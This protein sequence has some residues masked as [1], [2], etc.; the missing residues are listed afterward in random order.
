MDLSFEQPFESPMEARRNPRV[1]FIGSNI[2]TAEEFSIDSASPST[3][4]APPSTDMVATVR[5]SSDLDLTAITSFDVDTDHPDYCDDGAIIGTVFGADLFIRVRSAGVATGGRGCY[6]VEDDGTNTASV[7]LSTSATS[8]QQEVEVE[9][10]GAS[11]QEVYDSESFTI[12]VEEAADDPDDVPDR[13]NGGGG[14][15]EGLDIPGIP[16]IPGL[17]DAQ[18]GTAALVFLLVVLLAVAVGS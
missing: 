1:S 4:T 14:D 2:V 8:G 11:T 3:F 17:S 7:P 12:S 15:D 9:L 5:F 16:D 6:N 18:T 10:V 13:G